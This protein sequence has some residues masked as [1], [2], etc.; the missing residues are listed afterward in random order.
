MGQTRNADYAH[1]ARSELTA[2][3]RAIRAQITEPE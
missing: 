3:M 1:A 2:D